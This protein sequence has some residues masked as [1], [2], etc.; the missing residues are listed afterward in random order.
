[1]KINSYNHIKLIISNNDMME[2]KKF[3]VKKFLNSYPSLVMTVNQSP[4]RKNKW[5]LLLLLF[6]MLL[7]W[8]LV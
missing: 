2:S 6:I 1:M 4:G 7:L 8:L 5:L 3:R